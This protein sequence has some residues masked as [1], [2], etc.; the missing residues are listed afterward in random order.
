MSFRRENVYD[1]SITQGITLRA[2]FDPNPLHVGAYM[3]FSLYSSQAGVSSV[4]DVFYYR[5]L[6]RDPKWFSLATLVF[7]IAHEEITGRTAQDAVWDLCWNLIVQNPNS[8]VMKELEGAPGCEWFVEL[9]DDSR[10]K[11]H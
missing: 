2:V 9:R 8:Y 5:E 4:S 1:K 6:A 3:T 11:I 10:E 7:G